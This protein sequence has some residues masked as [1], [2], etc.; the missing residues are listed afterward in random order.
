ML[1]GILLLCA[2]VSVPCAT[3]ALEQHVFS[4]API[5]SAGT[6]WRFTPTNTEKLE[7]MVMIA[8]THNLDIWQITAGLTPH[9]DIY[10]PSSSEP[11]PHAL[12]DTPHSMNI[13]SA[14]KPSL[15][16]SQS[17]SW[18]LDSLVNTTFHDHYHTQSEVDEFIGEM[19]QLH[20]ESVTILRLGNTGE[21]R[22][23]LGLKISAP[24]SKKK[25]GIV[26]QGSQ[27]AREWVATSTALYL[28]HALLANASEANSLSYLL[29]TYEFHIIPTP[30]PDGYTY[31]WENDRFWYKNRQVMDPVGN[32]TGID[33]AR[34]WG[35][36]WEANIT[37]PTP[38]FGP[39][40]HDQADPCSH[41]YPGHRAFEAPE[42]NNLANYIT[43][44]NGA[45]G[46]EIVAFLE[47]RSYGQLLARPYAYTCDIKRLPQ[48]AALIRAML[49]TANA[50]KSAYGTPFMT[51]T[52]CELLYYA[53]PGNVLDYVYETAGIKYAYTAF[54]R[55]TGLYG[56]ALPPPWIRPVGEETGDMVAYLGRFVAEKRGMNL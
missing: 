4:V 20:S 21:G 15:L 33:M 46:V 56:F 7:E 6:L 29:D 31:T 52:G 34:N 2:L 42:T 28:A 3:T 35:Y 51:G 22:Q 10:T 47:L 1:S 17:G 13:I 49:G 11:L 5:S 25:L 14:P 23:M 48:D 12:M 18:N 9:A 32:C 54:L 8:Q 44:A 39:S 50:A 27:H 24:G 38:W 19:A 36:R 37:Q 30:N 40:E 45:N 53:T 16:R 26:I 41:W 43:A 55:D